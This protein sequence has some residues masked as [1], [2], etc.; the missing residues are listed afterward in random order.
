MK[1]HKQ[2][3]IMATRKDQKL[4]KKWDFREAVACVIITL[5]IMAV[6]ATFVAK[7]CDSIPL[8]V[9]QQSEIQRSDK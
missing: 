7:F 9:E 3:P 1:K 5:F 4:Q 6:F 2:M 8:P